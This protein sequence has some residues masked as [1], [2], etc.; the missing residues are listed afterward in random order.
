MRTG[1]INRSTNG[2]FKSDG[3]VGVHRNRST[4]LN[5]HHAQTR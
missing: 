5:Y 1:K 4:T 3:T 2:R